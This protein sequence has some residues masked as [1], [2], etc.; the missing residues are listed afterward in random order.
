MTSQTGGHCPGYAQANLVVLP[1]DAASDF[2]DLCFRNPVP[3]PLLGMTPVGDFSKIDNTQVLND[4]DFDITTDFPK[5]T[6]FEKGKI[7][8]TVTDIK[9]HWNEK[10]VGFLIGCS[11][12]FEAA[13]ANAGLP[14][15]N[16]VEDKSVSMYLT[17][18]MLDPAGI[19]TDVYYV[20]SM[21]P[22]KKS[23]LAKVR[24]ITRK[25]R[26][27]H[28]E[29]IYWGYGALKRLGISDLSKPDFGET[30]RLN[31]DEV[32]VFWGCGVTA[33]VAALTVSHK[34]EGLTFGH[35]PGHMLVLDIKDEEVIALR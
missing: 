13:L 3:L 7:V 21:R 24:E 19:F 34:I 2:A 6:V 11:Y 35:A 32:P 33:Q 1:K 18:K 10:H 27:T 8:G 28:G 12:S 20:V 25:F 4:E 15:R 23:D 14:A 17:S 30:T 26:K 16:S 31:D 5:Y 22:Y 9:D 29:P